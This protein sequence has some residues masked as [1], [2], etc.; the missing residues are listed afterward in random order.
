MHFYPSNSPSSPSPR[1]L[2]P[3]FS[4]NP[5]PIF[6]FDPQSTAT[7]TGEAEE[8]SKNKR[9]ISNPAR[10]FFR[11]GHHNMSIKRNHFIFLSSDRCK[12][13]IGREGEKKRWMKKIEEEKG[14]K[15]PLWHFISFDV[16]RSFSEQPVQ[17]IELLS[18]FVLLLF[19]VPDPKINVLFFLF[20]RCSRQFFFLRQFAIA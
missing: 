16:I 4:F 15:V 17:L 19:N 11:L 13:I 7:T 14:K 9:K 6:P 12:S 2:P 5:P 8:K 18:Y 20:L 10:T 3:T 1:S